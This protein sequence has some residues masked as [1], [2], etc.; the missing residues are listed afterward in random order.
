MTGYSGQ[1]TQGIGGRLRTVRKHLNYTRQQ[2]ARVLGVHQSGYYKNEAGETY[3]RPETLLKLQ[4]DYGISMDWLLSNKGPM[5]YKEKAREKEKTSGL[6]E[7]VPEVRE[8]VDHMDRDPQ[9]KHEILA[10]FFKYRN[11][12]KSPEGKGE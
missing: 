8:L 5:F 7:R 12:K 3:P 4:R 6:E 10:F 9:L 1:N 2:M 11:K